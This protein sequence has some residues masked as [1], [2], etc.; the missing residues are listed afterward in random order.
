MGTG[1]LVPAF[2]AMTGALYCDDCTR[3]QRHV[4]RVQWAEVSTPDP[5]A[6]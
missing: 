4:R 2:D 3:A 1:T 6:A 5:E